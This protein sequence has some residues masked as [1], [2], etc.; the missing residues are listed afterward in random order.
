VI[1]ESDRYCI[2]ADPENCTEAVPGYICRKRTAP[3]AP[4]DAWLIERANGKKD[5]VLSLP[6]DDMAEGDKAHALVKR[7]RLQ[8]VTSAPLPEEPS[9]MIWNDSGAWMQYARALR[10]RLQETDANWKAAEANVS[11]YMEANL[12]LENKLRESES[13]LQEEIAKRGEVERELDDCRATLRDERYCHGQTIASLKN[14]ASQ[15]IKRWRDAALS[16]ESPD[17]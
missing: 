5:A 4:A 3:S 7:D 14:A 16:K 15:E 2:C 12:Q 17:E 8:Q 6:T 11:T 10:A 13:R 1:P 9:G